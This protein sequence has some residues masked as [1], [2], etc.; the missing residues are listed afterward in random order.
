MYQTYQQNAVGTRQVRELLAQTDLPVIVKGILNPDD[1][2]HLQDLGVAGMVVSNHGG[3]TLDGVPA[4]LAVLAAIR[5][6]VGADYPLL[7]DGGIRSGSDAFKALTL[8]AN[9]ILIGRLPL[10][11]LAVAGA[12][13]VAHMLKLLRE[14]L[15]LAMAVTGCSN[16]QQI[17]NT[18]LRK[19]TGISAC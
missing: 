12:L 13:G 2:A 7:F 18:R 10:Y 14:E 4:S 16:I 19:N 5:Q 8:G 6:R 9:A 11:A 1:A 3:R 15:E 17:D